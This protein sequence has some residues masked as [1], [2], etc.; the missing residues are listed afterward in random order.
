MRFTEDGKLRHTPAIEDHVVPLARV[1]DAEVRILGSAFLI[2]PRGYALTARHCVPDDIT[3]FKVLF[4]T[5][6]G[7]TAVEPIAQIEHHPTEDVS[8]LKF[9]TVDAWLGMLRLNAEPRNPGEEFEAWGYPQVTYNSRVVEGKVRE[10]PQMV[11]DR[12]Y[13]RRR[14][15]DPHLPNVRGKFLYELSTRPGAGYSGSP[16][17]AYDPRGSKSWSVIGIYIGEQ[18]SGQTH[19]D[20]LDDGR[21]VAQPPG[22]V[23][24]IAHH[25]MHYS[26]SDGGDVK[27]RMVFELND[28]HIVTKAPA[29]ITVVRQIELGGTYFGYAA[30][31]ADFGSWVPTMLGHSLLVE[32]NPPPGVEPVRVGPQ[33][34]AG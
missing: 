26:D 16:I 31:A 12:G 5:D 8:L 2:G 25:R 20:V 15:D 7:V 33:D 22:E 10:S 3:H 13:I 27:T 14:R 11:Y 28:G 30:R 4:G 32:A 6:R 1:I 34:L 29:P 24:I 9:T 18:G 19:L 23:R 17:C 21:V